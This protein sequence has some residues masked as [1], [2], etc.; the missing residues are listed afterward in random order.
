MAGFARKLAYFLILFIAFGDASISALP[1]KVNLCVASLVAVR[2]SELIGHSNETGNAVAALRGFR[3]S[4][5]NKNISDVTGTANLFLSYLRGGS[6]ISRPF[7]NPLANRLRLIEKNFS[8]DEDYKLDFI[9]GIVLD[10]SAS[11][12][13]ENDVEEFLSDIPAYAESLNQYHPGLN[14]GHYFFWFMAA[15][16]IINLP[17]S[18]FDPSNPQWQAQLFLAIPSYYFLG[19]DA[20]LNRIF[21]NGHRI[22][23]G[24][25]RMQRAARTPPKSADDW[26][27]FSYDMKLPRVL[28]RDSWS[29]KEGDPAGM[30]F[31]FAAEDIGELRRLIYVR[32]SIKESYIWMGVDLLLLPT[33]DLKNWRLVMMIRSDD[34]KPKIPKTVKAAKPALQS[35]LV[36][37]PRFNF[38]GETFK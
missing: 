26:R 17:N 38:I 23:F 29:N 30:S 3:V 6:L 28:F 37:Q 31:Q 8:G 7:I 24:L 11:E 22:Q 9:S 21:G 18:I 35:G 36:A 33:S 34:R 4:T 15:S 2:K 1:R 20:F 32:K 27:Y 13:N 14:F 10:N 12:K 25:R 16:G 19:T 5:L